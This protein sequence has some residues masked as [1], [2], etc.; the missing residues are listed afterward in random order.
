[1]KQSQLLP[2]RRHFAEV[3]LFLEHEST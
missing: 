2:M 1:M 3:Q